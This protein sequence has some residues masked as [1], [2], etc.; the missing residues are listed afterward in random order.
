MLSALEDDNEGSSC[1]DLQVGVV[2][3]D[4][5]FGNIECVKDGVTF[6]S[7]EDH[8]AKLEH[9]PSSNHSRNINESQLF[10][11]GLREIDLLSFVYSVIFRTEN[12]TGL[13]QKIFVILKVHNFSL[14]IFKG[15]NR[16][17]DAC[18]SLFDLV[19]NSI[20]HSVRCLFAILQHCID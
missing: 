3:F 7:T 17:V 14:S 16:I 8:F 13:E 11:S 18:V 9:V 15:P 2:F 5:V 10:K 6:S 4:F 1:L 19:L 20:D 12:L